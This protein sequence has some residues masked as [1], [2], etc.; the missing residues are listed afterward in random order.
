[1]SLQFVSE[2]EV[3]TVRTYKVFGEYAWANTYEIA[4]REEAESNS[5]AFWIDIADRFIALE[6][7][8][9]L[10][11]V[12]FD[13][14]VISTYIPDGQPYNPVSFTA[15]PYSVPGL[16]NPT[17][18]LL[19]A[20]ACLYVRRNALFGRDGRLFYRGCLHEAFAESGF[21][22]HTITAQRQSQIQGA[23][24]S[25]YTGFRN[26]TVFDIVLASGV[27]VPTSVRIVTDFVV[28]RRIVYKKP[29]NRY[30]DRV[31]N[32]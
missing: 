15:F 22:R 28:E 8:F 32:P 10:S 18:D 1:M 25:W 30:F 16:A 19:P 13:R 20:D 7:E 9:H 14:V 17:S 2:G 5:Q 6:R 27:P 3:F 23:F 31:R 24:D 12:L 29:K 21:P 11:T 4:A 26:N